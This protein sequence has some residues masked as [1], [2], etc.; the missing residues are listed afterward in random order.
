MALD[1]RHLHTRSAREADLAAHPAA[2]RPEGRSTART[3]AGLIRARVEKSARGERSGPP[4]PWCT[5]VILD[6]FWNMLRNKVHPTGESNHTGATQLVGLRAVPGVALDESSPIPKRPGVRRR[7]H[8]RFGRLCARA[9][10]V[11]AWCWRALKT[12]HSWTAK[13]PTRL[14]K[15]GRRG[16]RPGC[17]PGLI[18]GSGPTRRAA[19]KAGRSDARGIEAGADRHLVDGG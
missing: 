18:G 15:G 10:A 11:R 2:G 13:C 3:T 14:S 9:V 4:I 12:S 5:T 16:D 19:P 7:A 8:R 6:I 17:S 1:R